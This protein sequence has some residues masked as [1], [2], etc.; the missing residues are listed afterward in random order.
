[1]KL[2]L[3]G[4]VAVVVLAACV[5]KSMAGEEST[6][7]LRQGDRLAIC[8]DSITEQRLYSVYIA[9]YLAACHPELDLDCTMSGRPGETAPAFA[10][11]MEDTLGWFEPTV[12]TTFFGMN[13]GGYKAYDPSISDAYRT[14][15]HTVVSGLKGLGC[16]RLLISSPG[17]VDTH[18]F[19]KLDPAVYNLN[20]ATLGN[21]ARE[22][23]AIQRVDYVEMHRFQLETMTRCK[24][25]FGSD[26]KF[27]GDGVHLD[28]I[29]HVFLAYR[30]LRAMNLDADL[31]RIELHADGKAKASKGH[32]I[33]SSQSG[34]VTV[35]STRYPY[36]LTGGRGKAPTAPGT[37]ANFLPFLDDLSRF[38]LVMPDCPW[39]QVQVQW[40]DAKWGNP[41]VVVT[42]EQM[43]AGYN[44][45]TMV[46]PPILKDFYRVQSVDIAI[47]L[48]ISLTSKSLR[49][50]RWPHAQMLHGSGF[51]S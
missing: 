43:Q 50:A 19:K 40:G 4:V 48:Y 13:D 36:L 25:K 30:F 1:M 21:I 2:I 15:M 23:A 42:R 33:V 35:E 47:C 31:A 10:K 46:H 14:G 9:T 5:G 45:S 49:G 34:K 37:M 12:A 16:Q 11:R 28:R 38:L 17:S 3:A 20:L 39:E 24:E 29:G 22:V 18:Y 51:R 8:G 32:R 41:I 7:Q 6:L 44:L 26:F 27:A